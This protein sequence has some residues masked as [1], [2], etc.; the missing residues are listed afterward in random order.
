MSVFKDGTIRFDATNA[1]LSHF[2]PKEVGVTVEHV[3]ANGYL[4]DY[5]G[6]PLTSPNQICELKVQDIVIPQKLCNLF[7]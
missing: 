3:R 7:S 1:P 5:Q 2:T 4:H 6:N